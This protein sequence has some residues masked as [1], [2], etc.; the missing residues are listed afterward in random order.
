[1]AMPEDHLDRVLKEIENYHRDLPKVRVDKELVFVTDNFDYGDIK[2]VR[3]KASKKQWHDLYWQHYEK[4]FLYD[5]VK[6]YLSRPKAEN[7]A[8]MREYS[9]K[10]PE[11]FSSDFVRCIQATIDYNPLTKNRTKSYKPFEKTN[12]YNLSPLEK[13]K[14]TAV[15]SHLYIYLQ[16]ISKQSKETWPPYLHKFLSVYEIDE[17]ELKNNLDLQNVIKRVASKKWGIEFKDR[18][19]QTFVVDKHIPLKRIKAVSHRINPDQDPIL[20]NLFKKFK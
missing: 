15:A 12:R 19:W 5:D 11:L 2:N 14:I 16:K 10:Y 17:N 7:I 8:A 6:Q 3:F 13:I 20:S 18:F 9:E 4:D 1:M